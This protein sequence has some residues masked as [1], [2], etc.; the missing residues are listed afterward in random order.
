MRPHW[1]KERL[2]LGFRAT[3]SVELVVFGVQGWVL[4][5]VEWV[6]GLCLHGTFLRNCVEDLIS[7]TG[8]IRHYSR[9]YKP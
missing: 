7:Q 5:L 1:E 6:F 8:E 9:A 3:P 4:V 2:S